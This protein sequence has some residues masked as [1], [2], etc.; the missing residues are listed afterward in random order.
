MRGF[1]IALSLWMSCLSSSMASAAEPIKI[2]ILAYR[3]KPMVEQ[4]WQ[5]L[6]VYLK[7][8]LG[9][10]IEVSAY[11]Y[12]EFEKAILHKQLDVIITNPAHYIL[13]RHRNNLSAPLV[14]QV[15]QNNEFKLSAFGGVIFTRAD[16]RSISSMADLSEHSIAVTLKQ[17]FGG[18]KMQAYEL[19]SNDFK[20]PDE[21]LIQITG[22]PH[23]H[24]VE[25]VL[26]GR[27]D[28]GFVRTGLL[29]SMSDEGKID[30]SQIKVINRQ[31]LPSFPFA[32]STQLYPEWPVAVMPNVSEQLSRDLTIALLSLQSDH[33][34]AVR[35]GIHGFTVPADYSGVER[36]LRSLRVSPFD[37]IPDFTLTDL[38]HKYT[39]WIIASSFLTL[40][41]IGTGIKLI[42]QNRLIR[43][44]EKELK[45]IRNNLSSTIDAMPDLIFELGLDGTYY[46]V[47][48]AQRELLISSPDSLVGRKVS[49]VMP[50]ES[51]RICLS[52]LQQANDHKVVSGHEIWLDIEGDKKW[53]ELSTSKKEDVNQTQTQ[54]HFIMISRDITQRKKTEEQLLLSSRVFKETKE[55]ILV[56]D[57]NKLIIDV[58]PAFCEITE[59]S[60]DE[61]IGQSIDLLNP[62]T[63]TPEFASQMWD[64][65]NTHGSWQGEVWNRKKSGEPYAELISISALMDSNGHTINYL[66]VF[67]DITH[68]KEQQDQLNLIAHYDVLTRLPNRI[69][70][71]DRFQ[72]AVAHC[73]RKGTQ[74]AVCFLD[75][76]NFKPVN[77][78][79]GHEVGDKLLIEVANRIV[80]TIREEDT[81]S[82]QGGDEFTLI[83]SGLESAEQCEQTLER[84]HHSLAQPYLIDGNAHTI[85]ASSGFTMYPEDDG[86]I[87]TLLRHADQAMYQS[88]QSGR[89]RYRLFN[90]ELD[91]KTVLKHHQ[92]AELEQALSN[93]EFVL[94]YQPK[95][96]MITGEIL[97]AEALIRWQH[98]ENGLIPPLDFLP[99]VD[100]TKLEIE[101][102]NWV[103]DQA[104][105]QMALWQDEGI[106]L[107]ISINIASHHLLATSFADNLAKA[108]AS[109]PS[110]SPHKLQLEILESSSLGDIQAIRN[111]INICQN[112]L[113]V[114]IALDDFGTGYS[115]LTH[116]RNLSANIVKIDQSFV[117]DLQDDFDD[118]T[119]VE[120]I[121][122]LASSFSRDIIAEGVE[123]DEQG[124]ML[125]IM[126]C[127]KAQGYGI[128]RPLPVDQLVNWIASYS[129]NKRWLEFGNLSFPLRDKKK[130]IFIFFAQQ[131]RAGFEDNL[132]RNQTDFSN[133]PPSSKSDPCRRWIDRENREKL[134]DQAY[135]T[136]L[137]HSYENFK[138]TALKQFT[139]QSNNDF[140]ANADGLKNIQ[141]AFDQMILALE[142]C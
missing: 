70:F 54:P 98:P 69:L 60:R 107:E 8:K 3:P 117:R 80:S 19:L 90:A 18:Y 33:Q 134:F 114:S 21:K 125:M 81:V 113:G 94:F 96:N 23:D 83:L 26:A 84:L 22:M 71:A 116:L 31:Q 55:G 133:W 37:Y 123:T 20:L 82:R 66:A 12:S 78:N 111:I 119:I 50:L 2:G 72:Q 16:N 64:A 34:A 65:I 120:G 136:Q 61:A 127:E 104:L 39:R 105:E 25:A 40:L 91:Q 108:L 5:P 99:L 95:I 59:Y 48:S 75:L 87:D 138:H 38:W 56:T 42:F 36:L 1:L 101:L 85:T 52:A 49:D 92:L 126:G 100:G 11:A 79:F 6:G 43:R 139:Q 30:L 57:A 128:S 137:M 62:G 103:I 74:L 76:D 115:S 97:G 46:K 41:L 142:Q 88:K 58:N 112:S 77:D 9:R 73:K 4:Q 14:T 141:L 45:S 121:I 124:L 129:P 17:S 109:Q 32:V 140:S 15:T 47:L 89:N 53:F 122:G 67:T 106:D 131:L 132:K 29:E 102:G 13:L 10:D 35:A 24:V 110:V 68:S 44:S 93:N 7:D 51:A 63:Q 28:A 130:R 27:A 118:Y 135:L 86:D